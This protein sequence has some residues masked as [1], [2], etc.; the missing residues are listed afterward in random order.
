MLDIAVASWVIM[1]RIHIV[2]TILVFQGVL[3]SRIHDLLQSYF[4]SYVT[5][6]LRSFIYLY[7]KN[8]LKLSPRTEQVNVVT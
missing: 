8:A 7:V 4:Q 1:A 6:A 5:H 2:N 3:F